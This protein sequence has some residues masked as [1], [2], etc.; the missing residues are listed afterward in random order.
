MGQE[1]SIFLNGSVTEEVPQPQKF[2]IVRHYNVP[3][4]HCI[5]S[6]YGVQEISER[7]VEQFMGEQYLRDRQHMQ[8]QVD[9]YDDYLSQMAEDAFKEPEPYKPLSEDE[10][11]PYEPGFEP[12]NQ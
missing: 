11:E 8:Q 7:D 3:Q 9:D 6:P 1:Q 4:Q 10:Y 12:W 2:P 5:P